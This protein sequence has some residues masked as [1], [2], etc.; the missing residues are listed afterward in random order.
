MI[1]IISK[2]THLIE[3]GRRRL[4]NE[5]Y[6]FLHTRNIPYAR[7]GVG[8]GERGEGMEEG[9]GGVGKGGGMAFQVVLQYVL[10]PTLPVT[11]DHFRVTCHRLCFGMR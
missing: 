6:A 8:S 4:D 3:G 2:S 10:S 1:T 9:S 5:L 11:G 7:C